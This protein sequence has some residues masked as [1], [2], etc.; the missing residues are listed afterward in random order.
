[1]L[2]RD[3]A[4][5]LAVP[6]DAGHTLGGRRIFGDGKTSRGVAVA[7]AGSTVAASIQG[8]IPVEWVASM[9][10]VDYAQVNPAVVGAAMG[11]GAM[12][13]ELPNSFLKRRLG[14]ERG[15]TARGAL[16]VVFYMFDQ[17]DL[18]LGAWPMI[19]PWVRPS[20]SLVAASIVV[21]LAVHPMVALLGYLMGA[22][23]SAR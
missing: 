22:R 6:I 3:L 16:G 8:V 9:V 4:S 15:Q 11:A 7:I 5:W 19:S 23:T 12:L 1:M 14:I 10:V 2:R 17:L 21:T 20:F 18:L 13:G